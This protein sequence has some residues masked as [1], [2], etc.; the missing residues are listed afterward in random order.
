M[1]RSGER[2]RKRK[3]TDKTL[4]R[5]DFPQEQLSE[6]KHLIDGLSTTWH[7]QA[8]LLMGRKKQPYGSPQKMNKE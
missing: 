4:S 7:L 8:L 1:T 2:E 5:Y 3:D 6:D